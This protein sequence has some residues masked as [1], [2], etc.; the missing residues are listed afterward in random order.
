MR[1]GS[2]YAVIATGIYLF[3]AIC[4]IA[5]NPYRDGAFCCGCFI[6]TRRGAAVESE[7][8]DNI[9]AVKPAEDGDPTEIDDDQDRGYSIA[10]EEKGEFIN[11]PMEQAFG[12]ELDE[13]QNMIVQDCDRYTEAPGDFTAATRSSSEMV[14]KEEERPIDQKDTEAVPQGPQESVEPR[15]PDEAVA[16]VD[17]DDA[18]SSRRPDFLDMCCGDPLELEKYMSGGKAVKREESQLYRVRH[19]SLQE[20]SQKV[21][22]LNEDPTM[23]EKVR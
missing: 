11:P 21:A 20:A 23:K 15:T 13:N 9:V 1:K 3:M 19:V 4:F 17:A 6:S 7:D 16:V 18:S 10:D 5:M 14:T 8:V 22:L 2:L 12:D